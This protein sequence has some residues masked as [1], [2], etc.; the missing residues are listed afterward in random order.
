MVDKSKKVPT[1]PDVKDTHTKMDVPSVFNLHS[2]LAD[3][4]IHYCTQL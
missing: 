1:K 2:Q 4:A 3:K